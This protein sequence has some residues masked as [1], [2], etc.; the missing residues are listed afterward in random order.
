MESPDIPAPALP[1]SPLLIQQSIPSSDLNVI[2]CSY[3]SKQAHS[4]LRWKNR[5]VVLTS[6]ALHWF[7]RYPSDSLF[8]VE[9]GSVAVSAIK[10]ANKVK[11]VLN[12]GFHYFEV[13]AVEVR[14][15]EERRT[16]GA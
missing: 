10:R 4:T 13:E 2:I 12:D 6:R 15:S 8:G 11:N 16:A 3:L 9:L 7:K 14:Q 1:P 5:F